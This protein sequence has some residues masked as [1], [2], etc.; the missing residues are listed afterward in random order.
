MTLGFIHHASAKE[1]ACTVPEA[2]KENLSGP[3]ASMVGQKADQLLHQ[4]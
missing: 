2:G 1:L 4:P 3:L